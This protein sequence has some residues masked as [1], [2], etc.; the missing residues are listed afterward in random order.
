MLVWHEI[1]VLRMAIGSNKTKNVL[2]G[3]FFVFSNIKKGGV[4]IRNKNY[5]TINLHQIVCLVKGGCCIEKG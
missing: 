5:V 3:L 1:H 2:L 4:K